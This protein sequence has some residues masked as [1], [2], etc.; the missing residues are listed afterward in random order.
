MHDKI[1]MTT[2][3][4]TKY[5]HAMRVLQGEDSTGRLQGA[6]MIRDLL[7]ANSL[8]VHLTADAH[9]N[10]GTAMSME[11][12]HGEAISA[13]SAALDIR[14]NSGFVHYNLAISLADSGRAMEA[15][16][17]YRQAAKLHDQ[18]SSI[19]SANNN[20]GNLLVGMGRKA[21]AR[22]TF[23]AAVQADPTHAMALN[24][25]ANLVRED[26]DDASLRAAGRAYA[27][28]VRLSPRYLEAYK[29]MGN[30]LKEREAWRPSAVRAYRVALALWSSA[31]GAN[32]GA[33]DATD[34][35]AT[36]SHYRGGR[37]VSE[38]G[39]LL[40]NL[41]ETLQWLG[42]ERAANA[43]FA[44]GAARGVWQHP[45]QRPSH[46][47]HGLRA[48]AWW[49]LQELPIVRRLLTPSAL[50]V[51]RA[52]GLRMLR[53]G[54][55]STGAAFRPYYSP[56]LTD[57]AWKDVTLTL[58]GT[59]QPGASHAPRSYALLETLGE[60]TL[61]YVSRPRSG[62]LWVMIAWPCYLCPCYLAPPLPCSCSPGSRGAAIPPCPAPLPR[63]HGV[64]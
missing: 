52:D 62:N 18:Q 10:L 16:M 38:E 12:R 59:R 7:S 3:A 56:A 39:K 6:A 34:A 8:P 14:P 43:T 35:G 41:G 25:W 55:G 60:D 11:R 19:S 32:N 30:L 27:A 44:L 33:A 51:L 20:L 45:Q 24:N 17:H 31:N 40:L 58:S 21:E 57:G 61:T 54:L 48:A 9:S 47:Q 4:L 2:A 50:A 26:G 42:H 64:R 53:G 36:R 49:S 5:G 13:F 37:E 46:L 22:A 63:Q 28:A 15:E 23:A 29:N 1:G